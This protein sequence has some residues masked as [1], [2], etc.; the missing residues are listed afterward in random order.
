MNIERLDD[1]TLRITRTD[2]F[3]RQVNTLDLKITAE[4][5]SNWISGMYIQDAM[6][7][8][9]ADEREFVKTGIMPDSWEKLF[10]QTDDF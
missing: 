3:S 10:P 1:N 6:P 2:P 8:L 5:W 9:S 4:Q 7:H